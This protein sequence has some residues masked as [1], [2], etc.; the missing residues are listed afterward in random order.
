MRITKE[1]FRA[2]ITKLGLDRS[3]AVLALNEAIKRQLNDQF[4]LAFDPEVDRLQSEALVA[5]V[6]AAQ[7]RAK[8]TRY[9]YEKAREMHGWI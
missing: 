1:S 2:R 8:L 3:A 6:K 5:E 7:A 9:C 4:T